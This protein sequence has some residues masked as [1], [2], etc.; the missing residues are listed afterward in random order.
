VDE[1]RA[2]VIQHSATAPGGYVN[3]W[4][5][6]RG[7]GAD[8][9]RVDA[10]DRAVAPRD[11]DLIV[12]LGSDCAAYD[13]S[14]PWLARELVLLRDAADAGVPVLGICFG[15]QL[16][17]RALGGRAMRG[18][19]PEIGWFPVRTR[20]RALVEEGR[21]LQ[22]HYDTFAPPPGAAL[23]ADSDAGRRLTPSDGTSDSSST[24]RPPPRS[25]KAGS[26]R[27]GTRFSTRA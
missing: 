14:V 5:A 9:Y 24:P 23:I 1:Q 27:I 6:D 17:A 11:Y 15:A 4:L 16:L 8:V 19:T 2:L 10:E 7:G 26:T 25:S 22:W 21:W 12:S 20:D 3:D 18:Q 13:D